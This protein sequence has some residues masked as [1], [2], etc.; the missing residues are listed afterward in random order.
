MIG[1]FGS[2]GKTIDIWEFPRRLMRSFAVELLFGGNS[3]DGYF[4]ADAVSQLIEGK[5]GSSAI[6]RIGLCADRVNT[7]RAA[8]SC[9]KFA[10]RHR[11]LGLRSH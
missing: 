6:G 9:R 10:R 3:E 1:V 8:L 7:G 5:W 11:Q 2:V 4:I